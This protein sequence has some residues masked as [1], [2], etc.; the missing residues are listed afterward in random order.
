MFLEPAP[1]QEERETLWHKMLAIIAYLLFWVLFTALGFW[2]LLEWREA[3]VQLMIVARL[4]PWAVSGFDRLVIFILGLTWFVC[5]LWV[6]HLLRSA[7][8]K[9]RLWP[10]IGRVAAIHALVTAAVF[11]I[12]FVLDQFTV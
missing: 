4:N 7:I 11:G 2:L 6:E 12:R 3:I 5:M 1:Q 9:R 10:T 8:S